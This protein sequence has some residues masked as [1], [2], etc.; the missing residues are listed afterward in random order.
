[1][2]GLGVILTAELVAIALALARQEN[3]LAFLSDVGR[4]SLVLLWLALT[5]SALLCI[6]RPHL[7]SR[8]L[9]QG[10]LI[11]WTAVQANVVVVSEVLYWIAYW[12]SPEAAP[13]R[14]LPSDHVF[15]AA[16]N[17]AVSSILLA[18]VLR[19]FYVADQW[20][21]NIRREAES[22]IH[23][24]QA[25]IRPHFLFNSMNTIAIPRSGSASGRNW[26][27]RGSTSEWSAS[28]SVTASPCSG[29]STAC[30]SMPGCRA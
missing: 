11:A 6:L 30:R 9:R 12:V 16:R 25:R 23:A 18:C 2:A 3:W 19:Y 15:F 4:T 13:E 28:A 29:S 17:V 26:K 24:L 10:T 22:R 14:W 1:M 7:A 21:R 8:E 5:S 20:Q 27:S